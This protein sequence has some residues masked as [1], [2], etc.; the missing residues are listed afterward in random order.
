ML[1]MYSPKIYMGGESVEIKYDKQF[2]NA[3]L[4]IA[5]KTSLDAKK[6]TVLQFYNAL[7]NI[8]Q[9]LEAESKSVKRHKRK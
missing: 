4:L 7:D 5:Q 8:K 1:N 9:R 6:M 3:C 2:E